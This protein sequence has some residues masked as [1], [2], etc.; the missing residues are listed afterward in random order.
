MK[1]ILLLMAIILPFVLTSCSKDNDE[2]K[3]LEQQLIGKWVS[4][5]TQD[6][7]NYTKTAIFSED[8]QLYLTGYKN[9]IQNIRESHTWSL[10]GNSLKLIRNYDSA[11]E[12]HTI[13]IEDDV[14]TISGWRETYHKE[15]E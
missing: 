4:T 7:D 6:G 8:H 1:K 12:T 14:L 13:S 3:S 11:E 10:E 5:W 2:P 9:D 15:K